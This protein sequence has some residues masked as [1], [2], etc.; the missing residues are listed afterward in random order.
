MFPPSLEGDYKDSHLFYMCYSGGEEKDPHIM[1]WE[2][3]FLQ[4][5]ANSFLPDSE[6]GQWPRATRFGDRSFLLRHVCTH[7]CLSLV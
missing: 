4:V 7:A 2:E 6:V 1:A 3:E 5:D